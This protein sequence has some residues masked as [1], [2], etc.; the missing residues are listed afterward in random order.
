MHCQMINRT[1]FVLGGSR[2]NDVGG[3]SYTQEYYDYLNRCVDSA[4]TAELENTYIHQ[5]QSSVEMCLLNNNSNKIKN[6]EWLT[7]INSDM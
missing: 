5:L 6:T 4:Q 1:D 3:L 7:Q 2:Y